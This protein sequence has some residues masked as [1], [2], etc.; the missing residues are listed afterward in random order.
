MSLVIKMHAHRIL[1][2][3]A[4]LLIKRIPAAFDLFN[5]NMIFTGRQARLSALAVDV[6]QADHSASGIVFHG[7]AADVRGHEADDIR[8]LAVSLL[9]GSILL[10]VGLA[11]L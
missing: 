10:K 2:D 6:E 1:H 4:V 7:L 11:S 5:I 3:V 9:H 8:S